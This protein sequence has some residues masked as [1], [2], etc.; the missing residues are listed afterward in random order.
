[1][2]DFSPLPLAPGPVY[3][4]QGNNANLYYAPGY[5]LRVDRDAV[6]WVEEQILHPVINAKETCLVAL[7]DHA[8]HAKEKWEKLLDRPYQPQSLH[9]YLNRRCQL[10]CQYCF[11]DLPEVM[12]A[13]EVSMDAACV[14][15]SLVAKNCARKGL[16]LVVVFHGG[17]EPVLSWRLIDALQPE[18]RRIADAHGISLFRYIA[19]NGVMSEQRAR[20]LA[21][22]FDLVGLSVDGPPDI[23]SKQR[24]HR[25][26]GRDDLDLILRTA[27]ILREADIPVHVRVTLTAGSALRQV[28]ICRYLCENFS[29]RAISVEPV[30]RGGRS[31]ASMQIR[32]DQLDGFT[33]AFFEARTEAHR[34]GVDWRLSGARLAEVHGPYCN[35]FRQVLQLAPDDVASAC[36][37]DV[38]AAQTHG[39]GLA[40][41]NF[42]GTLQINHRHIDFLR[43][44]FTRPATCATCFLGYH[45]TYNCPNACLLKGESTTEILCK[46]LKGIFYHRLVGLGDELSRMPGKIVGMVVASD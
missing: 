12:E 24:P 42:D 34:Y 17:G 15:A 13:V 21:G 4:L 29:P 22:S 31:D 3:R 28:E 23:Q 38:S 45:C 35:I 1:M 40:I 43:T 6:P 19:T 18:L 5:V 7:L 36:F 26:S 46:L 41:G 30:Y 27:R 8:I 32:E 10:A 2:P 25:R 9:L 37:K 33:Q 11:S 14:A 16:P 39:R 20:W 44:S